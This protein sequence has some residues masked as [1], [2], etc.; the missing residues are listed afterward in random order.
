MAGTKSLELISSIHDGLEVFLVSIGEVRSKDREMRLGCPGR[1]ADLVR[2]PAASQVIPLLLLIDKYDAKLEIFEF[3]FEVASK[4]R[5]S[6]V[7][8]VKLVPIAGVMITS[9]R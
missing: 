6:M 9:W 7:A 3:K 2:W 1:R 4:Y 5:M 8:W